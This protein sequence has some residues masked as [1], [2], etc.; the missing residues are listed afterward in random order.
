MSVN[1][2]GRKCDHSTLLGPSVNMQMATTILE[3][4]DQF[5]NQPRDKI[6]MTHYTYRTEHKYDQP[7]ILNVNLEKTEPGMWK[8]AIR[9]SR[10]E[11][12]ERG[13]NILIK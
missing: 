3:S 6:Q 2:Q 10:R 12:K 7:D 11:W 4:D 5:Q 9:E 8:Q 13:V 1:G